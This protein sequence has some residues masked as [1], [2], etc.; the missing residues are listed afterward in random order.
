MD[1]LLQVDRD[2]LLTCL[3]ALNLIKNGGEVELDEITK[4]RIDDAV[5]NVKDSLTQE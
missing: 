5:I 4:K 2:T 1:D 3:L